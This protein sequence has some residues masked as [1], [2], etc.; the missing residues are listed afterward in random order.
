MSRRYDLKNLT[1]QQR[2][3]ITIR[4]ENEK[5]ME[6][7]NERN[8]AKK[9]EE[10][11][12]ALTFYEIWETILRGLKPGEL[13]PNWTVLKGYKGDSMKI[14]QVDEGEIIV[15]TPNAKHLQHVSMAEFAEVWE[16]WP[17]YKAGR[18]Q[19]QEVGQMTYHSK[20][21]LSILHWFEENHL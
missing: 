11:K 10:E 8:S 16:I 13:I 9:D 12:L 1:P 5:L 14:V 4:D 18:M 6:N 15:Q 17:V 3:I 19:R 2:A 21:I 7:R 20:Y